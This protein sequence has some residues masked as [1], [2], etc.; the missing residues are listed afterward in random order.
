M[1]PSLHSRPWLDDDTHHLNCTLRASAWHTAVYTGRA[2][3]S[4]RPRP[5]TLSPQPPPSPSRASSLMSTSGSGEANDP[6]QHTRTPARSLGCCC[7]QPHRRIH[8]SPSRPGA[9]IHR[10]LDSSFFQRSVLPNPAAPPTSTPHPHQSFP[11]LPV[12]PVTRTPLNACS[13]CPF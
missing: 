8:P 4:T 7:T 1:P 5:S 10:T 9:V 6:P 2:Q 3:R 12:I 11:D 13:S